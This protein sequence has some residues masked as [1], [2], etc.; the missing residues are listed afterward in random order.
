[1]IP[2]RRPSIV[3]RQ[4]RSDKVIWETVLK[5]AG[6]VAVKATV[7][8]LRRAFAVAFLRVIRERWS[9]SRRS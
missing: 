2:N 5:V 7:H 1:V 6:R 9:R 4:E 8:A 3:R